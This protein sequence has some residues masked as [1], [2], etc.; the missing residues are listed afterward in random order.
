VNPTA[1]ANVGAGNFQLPTDPTGAA[2]DTALTVGSYSIDLKIKTL[3]KG[4]SSWT[5][6][7]SAK[8]VRQ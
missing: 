4:T 7:D 8:A 5:Y 3:T 1:P 2:L 6:F